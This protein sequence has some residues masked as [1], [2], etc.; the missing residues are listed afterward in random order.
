MSNFSSKTNSTLFQNRIKHLKQKGD[1]WTPVWVGLIVDEE[2]KHRK[3]MG[4]SIWIFLYLLLYANHKTH[5][6]RRTL[7]NIAEDTGFSV[8]SVHRHLNN[9]AKFEYIIVLETRPNLEIYI[10]KRKLFKKEIT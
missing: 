5:I 1:W 4:Q 7:K 2:N 3:R 6:A 8:R 9:L 10:E